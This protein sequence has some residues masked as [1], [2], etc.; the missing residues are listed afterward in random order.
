VPAQLPLIRA[1]VLQLAAG[2]LARNGL[3]VERL[4]GKAS[5]SPGA[6][7]KP[8]RTRARPSP[9][10]RFRSR[11]RGR[12]TRYGRRERNENGRRGRCQNG[13]ARDRREEGSVRLTSGLRTS[14]EMLEPLRTPRP[15]R[16]AATFDLPYAPGWF[17]R[18]TDWIDRM[19]GPNLVTPSGCSSSSSATSPASCGSTAGY[20]SGWST[21]GS[22]SSWSSLPI[23]C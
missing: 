3:R 16:H 22:P 10:I 4:L 23:S 13:R 17:D 21:C 14:R 15:A 20:P 7:E 1:V 8:E 2:F 11:S 18:L 9:T 12:S 6:L 19:P 5:L